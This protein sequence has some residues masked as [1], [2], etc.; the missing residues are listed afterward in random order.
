MR[1]VNKNV[2]VCLV[3]THIMYDKIWWIFFVCRKDKNVNLGSN[4]LKMKWQ[5]A[6]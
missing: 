2:N 5:I 4:Y 3:Q 1:I 6:A